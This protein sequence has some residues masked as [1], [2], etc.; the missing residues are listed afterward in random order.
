MLPMERGV[1]GI[2]LNRK[3]VERDSI[4]EWNGAWGE[5]HVGNWNENDPLNLKSA[6]KGKSSG[7]MG[8]MWNRTLDELNLY[9]LPPN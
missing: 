1:V 6:E 2:S 7:E 5:T 4:E 9:D 8:K 3:L